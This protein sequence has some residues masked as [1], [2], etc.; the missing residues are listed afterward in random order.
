[1]VLDS[2]ENRLDNYSAS[3]APQ[4]RV[5]QYEAG[6]GEAEGGAHWIRA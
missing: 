6:Q 3:P 4:P 2:T 1:M 5:G